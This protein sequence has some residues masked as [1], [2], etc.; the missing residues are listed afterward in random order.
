M[1][2]HHRR[3]RHSVLVSFL[4]VSLLFG[5]LP[6]SAQASIQALVEQTLP[7]IPIVGDVGQLARL[8]ENSVNGPITDGDPVATAVGEYTLT[9]VDLNLGGPLPLG[10]SR[11]FGSFVGIAAQVEGGFY[12]QFDS[13]MG[14]NWAHNFLILLKKFDRDNVGVYYYQGKYVLFRKTGTTWTMVQPSQGFTYKGT[15]YQLIEQG[16][17][18]KMMDPKTHLIYTFDTQ[19]LGNGAVRGVET[20]QDRNGNT[21]RLTYNRDSSLQRVEDGLGRSLDFTYITSASRPRISRVTDHAGR[22]IQFG[23]SNAQQASF[24]DAR[25]K[26]T[27]YTSNSGAQLESI[28]LPNGNTFLRNRYDRA[29]GRVI[30]QTDGA[31]NTTTFSYGLGETTITDPLGNTTV[32]EFDAEL[33]LIGLTDEAGKRVQ[34]EY[35][36]FHRRTA[37]IDRLGDRSSVTYDLASGKVT[38]RTDNE[39]KT[40]TYSYTP[41]Q[42]DGFTFYNLTRIDYP[43]GTHEE[44]IYDARGNIVTY[45]DRAGRVWMATYN[46]RGQ[47]TSITN[48]EGGVTTF[49]YN[50]DGTL[51]SVQDPAGNITTFDYDQ[52]KRLIRINRPDGTN[53]QFTYDAN[54]NLLTRT[55]ENGH[56]ISFTYDG[57]NNLAT[58]TNALG[59][60]WTLGYDG[61]DNLT[62]ITDPLGKSARLAYDEL[63]RL[64]TTTDRNGNT[65][66][67]N[68]DAR[69]RLTSMV[70]GEGKRWSLTYDDESVLTSFTNPLGQTW[71]MTSDKQGR[72]TSVT[73]P[74]SNQTRFG[75]DA[76]SRLI[77]TTNAL[78]QTTGFGYEARGLVSQVSMPG[79]TTGSYERNGLGQ[80]TQITDP[81]GKVRRRT[82]DNLGRLTA[83]I[84]ALGVATRVDRYDQRNRPVEIDLPLSTLDLTYDGIGLITNRSYSD[85][86]NLD[87]SYDAA[88]RLTSATGI[89]LGYDAANR[90]TSSNG[91]VITRDDGG[92][93]ASLELEPGKRVTYSYDRR[94]LLTSVTDWLG[95]VMRFAYDDAGRLISITRPN[96]VATTYSYDNAD[97]LTGITETQGEPGTLSGLRRV[98]VLSLMALTTVLSPMALTS[99]FSPIALTTA[100]SSIVS[101][102]VLSSIALT[103]DGIGQTT[104]ATRD[105]PLS[106]AP[107]PGNRTQT[108]NDADQIVGST[109]DR[110]GRLTDD[111]TRAY[112]WD[113]ASRLTSYTEGQNTVSFTYDAFRNRLSRTEGGH[114][115]SYVWNYALGLP[116]VSIIKDDGTT[117]RYYIHT[118]GGSLLYSIEADTNAR[119]FYHFDEMGSTLFLTNDSGAIT[120]SYAYT[121]YGEL[122]GATGTTDNPFTYIGQL[123]VMNEPGTSLYYMRARYYDSATGRF[124]SRDPLGEDLLDVKSLN[125]YHYAS[126]NPLGFVDPLGLDDV[127]ALGAAKFFGYV[128]GAVNN[129]F[130]GPIV[131][132]AYRPTG[133]LGLGGFAA[134]VFNIPDAPVLA[135]YLG[136]LDST[137]SPQPSSVDS[138]GPAFTTTGVAADEGDRRP[139]IE[140]FPES[141]LAQALR[142]KQARLAGSLSQAVPNPSRETQEVKPECPLG[143]NNRRVGT[144]VV[145]DEDGFVADYYNFKYTALALAQ[146]F[147]QAGLLT[148]RGNRGS[149]APPGQQR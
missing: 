71:T 13:P 65:I 137:D 54:D 25:G 130:G 19:G 99:V 39:G 48:P 128:F 80:V 88:N 87:Y 62:A 28:R 123:G 49:A 43:D 148:E 149:G 70:D 102:T 60:T 72:I 147:L 140:R 78:N 31:G 63:Q 84:D 82:L 2:F 32:H 85:G 135:P 103:R 119:R 124:L 132:P 129:D 111:G 146:L 101:T 109:Y 66:T 27:R 131:Q 83:I 142:A 73:D 1:T 126:Q 56:T 29:G 92:R 23:Y 3:K 55:D 118:P 100:L 136:G 34:H 15:P 4:L 16:T 12:G 57:N 117:G 6:G 122:T 127:D 110:M 94:D 74:L 112:T 79:P 68:Y 20:I 108:Y 9:I 35:D 26:V 75:Y 113:L 86:T 95:G 114:T 120:D 97:R 45:I 50:A 125:L 21:H 53:V 61:N 89:A 37:T 143:D 69:R 52:L 105:V 11:Y 116:S 121:P 36:N 7:L 44:F 141:I 42:Q 47:V 139:G 93:I 40:W 51:A 8:A 107:M 144:G 90:L 133:A 106:S 5:L 145:P 64:K 38:S 18:L 22:F 41:Q 104:Q 33:R 46:N 24:T 98:A 30:A 77:A 17:K 81:R 134:I 10:F 76:L 67:R 138:D 91:I 115:R 59:N 58:F 96:G 14:A